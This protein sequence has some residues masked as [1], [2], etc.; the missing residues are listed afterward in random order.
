M[1]VAF[2][3]VRFVRCPADILNADTY[4][5]IRLDSVSEGWFT[6]RGISTVFEF[7]RSVVYLLF[8]EACD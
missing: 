1:F 7:C 4:A 6:V 2:G 5:Y 3:V 8:E